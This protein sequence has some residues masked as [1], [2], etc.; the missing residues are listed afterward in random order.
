MLAFWCTKRAN[1]FAYGRLF[2]NV[3]HNIYEIK[4]KA[5]CPLMQAEAQWDF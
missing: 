1:G 4:V 2:M 3:L 5:E